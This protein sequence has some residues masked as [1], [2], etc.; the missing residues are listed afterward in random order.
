MFRLVVG[1]SFIPA[2]VCMTLCLK[3]SPQVL[4]WWQLQIRW[5]VHL[6]VSPKKWRLML[7]LRH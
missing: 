7:G 5:K 6:R 1:L 2:A 3:Y 4:S